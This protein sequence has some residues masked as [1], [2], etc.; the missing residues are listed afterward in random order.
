ML[1]SVLA[2]SAQ[3]KTNK[4]LVIDCKATKTSKYFLNV[5]NIKDYYLH[6]LILTSKYTQTPNLNILIC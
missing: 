4:P 2:A 6:F 3:M 5:K 1:K